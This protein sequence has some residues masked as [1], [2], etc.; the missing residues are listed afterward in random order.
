MVWT[1]NRRRLA[2][3]LPA[4]FLVVAGCYGGLETDGAFGSGA[5][6]VGDAGDDGDDSGDDGDDGG[7]AGLCADPNVGIDGL[8][9]LTAA[10]YDNTIRDL[11]GIANNPSAGFSPDERS[12][13]FKANN[14]APV[15]ELQVEQYMDAAEAV[16]D[17]AVADMTTLLPCDPVAVGEDACAQALIEDVGAKAYRRPLTA[18][19]VS[20][21]MAVY[22][23]AKAEGNGDFVNGIRVLL[24]AIL[25]SPYFIYRIEFGL[26]EAGEDVVLLSDHEVAARLSY[27]LWNTM[28]DE[29]LFSAAD[30]GELVTEE[31]LAAQVDRML[32]DPRAEAAISSFH[33][34]WLGTD[35]IELLEK[36]AT[37]YPEFDL[38]LAT[39]MKDETAAFARHV[40]LEGDGRLETLL[41]SAET[42]T[43]NTALLDLYGVQLPAG[44]QPGD[45]VT[46]PAGERAGLMTQASV[47][48]SAAHADQSS[49]ILR[50][51]LVRQNFFCQQLP[52]PPP[53]VDNVPP[54]PDPNA[55]TR[56]RFAEHTASPDCAGCH[57][58]IDPIGFG[59][60]AYDAIGKYRTMEGTLPVDDSGEL[61]NTD[62]DGPFNGGV[63][64]ANMMA[65]SDQVRECVASQWFR[66]AFGRSQTDD[67]ECTTDHMNE[68]FAE[69]DYDIRV[70]LREIAI[71]DS[72]RLRRT[73][74]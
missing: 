24:G 3:L 63:E 32:A 39:A 67:D 60:E 15:G 29:G 40:I 10:Q 69:S 17:V 45:P 1:R 27:F 31:G 53:D 26:P 72:F 12:G 42:V 23:A 59:F 6:S 18:G 20:G 65:T 11:L 51:V 7:P 56:E 2:V 28:P 66:Y 58:L 34:Q 46:L 50:G 52:S 4:G 61:I 35:E 44:H 33:V 48:A 41:T 54:D 36:S 64:L 30:A 62:I 5:D 55:T 25:Q 49:P 43:D 8:R 9:R 68:A 21:L 70:L 74:G 13:P 57:L 71:S 14:A 22:D 73:E 37:D 38:G 47:L 16:A 19:E